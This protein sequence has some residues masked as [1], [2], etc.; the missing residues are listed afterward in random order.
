MTGAASAQ[1]GQ[2]APLGLH[3]ASCGAVAQEQPKPS[4]TGARFLPRGWYAGDLGP[5]CAACAL[6]RQAASLARRPRP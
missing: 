1:A 6:P 5:E 4:R 2:G 3:C